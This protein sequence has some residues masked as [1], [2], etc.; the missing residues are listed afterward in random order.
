MFEELKNN[1]TALDPKIENQQKYFKWYYRIPFITAILI[2]IY[3]LVYSIL[4]AVAA[5]SGLVWFIDMLVGTIA[6][7]IEYVLGKIII[8]QKIL[9][10]LYLQKLNEK[11]CDIKS[12][13]IENKE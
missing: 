1:N 6:A 4:A 12:Q 11:A 7:V 9:T 8:S 10:V 3:S 13:E 2:L 5:Q